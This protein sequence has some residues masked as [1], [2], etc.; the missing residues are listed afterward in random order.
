[1]KETIQHE[2]LTKSISL[3]FF[4]LKFPGLTFIL[5]YP[6]LSLPATLFEFI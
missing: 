1:M 3:P 4:N 2:Q 6:L 5:S